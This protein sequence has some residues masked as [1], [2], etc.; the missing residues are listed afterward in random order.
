MPFSR[1]AGRVTLAGIL[2]LI[3][4]AA[5]SAQ[6]PP[7]QDPT[8][9]ALLPLMQ[10]SPILNAID[11]NHDAKIDAT[12]L[13]NAPAR[14]K[15][16][17]K[18]NDGK[19]TRDEAGL[20]PGFGRP[21]GPGR[22][23]RG[24]GDRGGDRG[25]GGDAGRAGDAG[26]GERNFEVPIPGP[27]ADE[28]LAALLTFDKNKDG[29]LTK[30]EVPERQQGI[31]ERGDTD[32]NGVLDPAELKKLTADQAAAPPAPPIQR[33]PGRGGFGGID[34]ASMLLDADKNGEISAEEIAN[35]PTAL[36]ALDKNSDGTITE[37]E[38]QPAGRGR[39]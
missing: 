39:G 17:D 23:G 31:F 24:E 16:L 29:K 30:A 33:G 36:K 35:A 38:V 7:A 18:N 9:P 8:A 27:T 28:L 22:G 11:V 34:A 10:A 15:T 37:D 2:A 4:C 19:L 5:L 26:G 25:R 32:K 14:L 6:T 13:A 3:S 20:P 21:A 1:A 12:E